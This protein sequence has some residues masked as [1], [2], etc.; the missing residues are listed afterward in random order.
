MMS[1]YCNFAKP[2]ARATALASDELRSAVTLQD[3]AA[4]AFSPI[5]SYRGCCLIS[6]LWHLITCCAGKPS[7]GLPLYCCLPSCRHDVYRTLR[8]LLLRTISSISV[9]LASRRVAPAMEKRITPKQRRSTT[10]GQ[11]SPSRYSNSNPCP[12]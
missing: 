10:K 1:P 2:R 7:C 8:L 9:T 12:L 3:T 5:L 4:V 6:Q 11:H